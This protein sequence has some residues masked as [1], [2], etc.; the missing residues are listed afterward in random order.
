MSRERRKELYEDNRMKSL[1]M[2]IIVAIVIAWSV[3]AVDAA[4]PIKFELTV[5]E[6][7]QVN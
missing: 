6:T 5:P 4:E 2:A 7:I 1:N 3:G